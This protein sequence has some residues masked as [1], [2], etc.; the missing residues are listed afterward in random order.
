MIKAMIEQ[1]VRMSRDRY[2]NV[3]AYGRY[4]KEPVQIE[5]IYNDS[6]G[7]YEVRTVKN[8]ERTVS[9]I[10][11][12]IAAVKEE[13]KRRDNKTGNMMTVS[14][15]QDGGIF[16]PDDELEGGQYT[17]K[18]AL[19]NQWETLKKLVVAGRS[20]QYLDH[21]RIIEAIQALKP[22]IGTKFADIYSCYSM[23]KLK[24]SST[25]TSQPIF[26]AEGRLGEG[27]IV[28]FELQTGNKQPGSSEKQYL[29][30]NLELKLPYAKNLTEYSWDEADE[31]LREKGV[32]KINVEISITRDR[33]EKFVARF[34]CPEFEEVEEQA[35]RDEVTKFKGETSELSELLVLEDY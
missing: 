9:N 13:A 25:L 15:A 35:I 18:R 20:G 5:A 31:K 34:L 27:Y 24:S 11:S 7:R 19:C 33:D 12:L 23:L 32:Y 4:K 8:I 30:I 17:Y 10:N 1:I 6:Q 3:P 28:D 29:P 26:D 22:S 21:L 2:A 16:Y 14:F